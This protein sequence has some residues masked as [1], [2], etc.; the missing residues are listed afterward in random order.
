MTY[1]DSISVLFV[2]TGDKAT[3]SAKSTEPSEVLGVQSTL[4]L[5]VMAAEE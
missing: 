3:M 4:A 5:G 2:T 1:E